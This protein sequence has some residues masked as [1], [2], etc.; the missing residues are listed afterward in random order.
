MRT[1]RRSSC[2]RK[3]G[4]RE[5]SRVKNTGCILK[6]TTVWAS[7]TSCPTW[8]TSDHLMIVWNGY[9]LV[10]VHF[11]LWIEIVCSVFL[12]YF[13]LYIKIFCNIQKTELLLKNLVINLNIRTNSS[14][15]VWTEINYYI[16]FKLRSR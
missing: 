4:A 5:R 13:K 8:S 16:Y 7:G 3:R 2:N 11:R 14:I 12:N 15:N 1:V 10:G 9:C 6:G